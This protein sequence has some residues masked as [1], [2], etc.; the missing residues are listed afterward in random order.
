[1]N[2]IVLDVEGNE[3]EERTI[4]PR[5]VR[6]GRAAIDRLA[7]LAG[8]QSPAAQ[9]I[10]STGSLD[11]LGDRLGTLGQDVAPCH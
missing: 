3:V 9:M 11:S 2:A 8:V 1:M 6:L 10:A 4:A 7:E 5:R